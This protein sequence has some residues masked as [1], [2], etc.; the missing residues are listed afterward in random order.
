MM[1]SG[2]CSIGCGETLKLITAK[3]ELTSLHL[4][5]EQK[6]ACLETVSASP[7]TS[8]QF[9]RKDHLEEGVN[10]WKRHIGLCV[11]AWV[12]LS[13]A[14]TQV[15]P[16]FP[17][18]ASSGSDAL[19]VQIINMWALHLSCFCFNLPGIFLSKKTCK[20]LSLYCKAHHHCGIRFMDT[21][22]C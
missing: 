16:L 12:C 22:L 1:L 5:V 14:C 8:G 3:V 7:K 18:S 15:L 17:V 2:K 9:S 19:R 13:R 20:C 10:E 21:Y 4:Q 6:I 11:C